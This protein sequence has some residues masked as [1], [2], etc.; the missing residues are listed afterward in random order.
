MSRT[1]SLAVL[2]TLAAC[3]ASGDGPSGTSSGTPSGTGT[4]TGTGGTAPTETGPR[5]PALPMA[6]AGSYHSCRI[7]AAGSIACWGNDPWTQV[8]GTP[9]D[10]SFIEI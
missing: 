7:D 8:S 5:S 6:A 1:L 3:G 4:G 2:F 9:A 10:G